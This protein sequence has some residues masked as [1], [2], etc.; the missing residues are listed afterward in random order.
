[1]ILQ[2]GWFQSCYHHPVWKGVALHL[3][4]LESLSLK[5]TLCYILPGGSGEDNEKLK[6]K[7]YKQSDNRQHAI[8]KC[9]LEL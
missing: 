3:N 6:I 9:S 5:D 4:K 1:M 8:K 2:A 7:V